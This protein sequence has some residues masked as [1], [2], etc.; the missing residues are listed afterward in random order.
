MTSIR[1][2][3][4]RTASR[5]SA[6]VAPA[7]AVLASTLPLLL[8]TLAHAEELPRLVSVSGQGEVRAL[9]D[10]AY[11]TIGVEARKPTL[12]E[13]RSQVNATVERVLALTRELKIDP[14][15]VDS[16]GL[17]VQ[18]EYR[19]NDKDSQRVLLGYV[20]SRQVEVQLRNLDQLGSLLE[21][22]VSA[23]ANQ[24]GSPRLDSSR[25]AELEREALSRAV[26]DAK[27]DAETLATAAGVRLGPVFSL[28]SS[29]G[30]PPRPM[31]AE[32]MLAAAPPMADAAPETYTTGELTFQASVS[33]QWTLE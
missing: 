20:V 24:V 27:L 6:T 11:L 33:A 30:P 1:P 21:R 31:M 18:P 25:R 28:S 23:G 14:K 29:G 7:L 15:H 12:A 4:R 10:M 22:S 26:A 8:P 2:A 13:A 9:P 19:W 32:R 17:Q 5:S 16:S 3:L